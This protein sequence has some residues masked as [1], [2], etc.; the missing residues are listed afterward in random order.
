MLTLSAALSHREQVTCRAQLTAS[1]FP[2]GRSDRTQAYLLNLA[3][4]I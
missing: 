2:A 1:A 4:F 3:A